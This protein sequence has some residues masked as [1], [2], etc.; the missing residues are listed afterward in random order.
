MKYIEKLSYDGNGSSLRSG[1]ATIF[2]KF[3]IPWN[4][5]VWAT[6]ATD[7]VGKYDS[8]ISEFAY[9]ADATLVCPFCGH[10]NC[11]S[12]WKKCA[13]EGADLTLRYKV[14]NSEDE[15]V[16][17]LPE[18]IV[19]GSECINLDLSILGII[20]AIRKCYDI[21]SFKLHNCKI[22]AIHLKSQLPKGAHIYL[23]ENLVYH[24][25]LD[26]IKTFAT[27]GEFTWSKTKMLTCTY[28]ELKSIH[29][30]RKI[31]ECKPG[32]KKNQKDN[33]AVIIE[34]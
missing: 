25:R 28:P 5:N 2:K 22:D 30:K 6:F 24:V 3:N 27:W 16:L 20:K 4:K 26:E 10:A 7:C 31:W 8:D 33:Y 17:I 14:P 11:L 15:L 18:F 1:L 34:K 12:L 23:K 13:T 29:K 19:C 32:Y 9:K 21:G